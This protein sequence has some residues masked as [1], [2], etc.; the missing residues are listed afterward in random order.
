MEHVWR[1]WLDNKHGYAAIHD[2]IYIVVRLIGLQTVLPAVYMLEGMTGCRGSSSPY[3][4]F[5]C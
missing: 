5:P 3:K 2:C 1:I 4:D